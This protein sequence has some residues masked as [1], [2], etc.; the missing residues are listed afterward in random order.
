MREISI[1][2]GCIKI[3]SKAEVFAACCP[4]DQEGLL[5]GSASNVEMY[6]FDSLLYK[7]EEVFG[8]VTLKIP[9]SYLNNIN[10]I[11]G[12][13]GSGKSNFFAGVINDFGDRNMIINDPTSDFVQW[14]YD[15]SK[16]TRDLIVGYADSRASIWDVFLE[17]RKDPQIANL[18]FENMLLGIKGAGDTKD[19]DWIVWATAWLVKL[20][21]KIN[22]AINCHPDHYLYDQIPEFIKE[23]LADFKQEA[24]AMSKMEGDALGIATTAFR[25]LYQMYWVGVNDSRKFFTAAD[26]MK[27]R[28]V[29]LLN[30]S[31]FTKMFAAHNSAF[32]A[33]LISKYMNRGDVK[34]HETWKFSIWILD[35]YLTFILDKAIKMLLLTQG[36]KKGISLYLGGQ[37]F[38]TEEEELKCIFG[39][40]I[41][42]VVLQSNDTRDETKAA[43]ETVSSSCGKMVYQWKRKVKSEAPR[44]LGL[45]NMVLNYFSDNTTISESWV[46][47]N[48]RQVPVELLGSM[49]QYSAYV[50][51]KTDKGVIRTFVKMAHNL[52]TN[53]PENQT[54]DPD[55]GETVGFFYS[56]VARRAPRI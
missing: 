45:S 8:E 50:Q 19:Q 34:A 35:E 28:R 5:I 37:S 43:L 10:Y 12:G 38:P 4:P 15:S 27:A 23:T 26:V 18:I 7:Q 42:T 31:L 29:F 25:L 55:T 3:S 32:L 17:I 30:N 51:L 13:M 48:T 21:D 11:L 20:A 56:D 41:L 2:P 22:G 53:K 1:S 6:N 24:A 9:F 40:R 46:D 36:R 39:S 14:A 16:D 44:Q 33:V 47:V 54:V 52:I 49:E